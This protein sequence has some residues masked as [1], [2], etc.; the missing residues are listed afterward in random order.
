GARRRIEARGRI[1]E[2]ALI[3]ETAAKIPDRGADDAAGA[4]DAAHLFHGEGG[5][6][7]E[8]QYELRRRTG[9]A[10]VGKWEFGRLR[11]LEGRRARRRAGLRMLHIGRGNVDTGDTTLRPARLHGE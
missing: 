9:E 6:A 7:D 2:D 11:H 10:S 1:P 8:I 5:I 3:D 4:H